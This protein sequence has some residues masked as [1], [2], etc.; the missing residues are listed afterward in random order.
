MIKTRTGRHPRMFMMAFPSN[1][2]DS[3]RAST[4]AEEQQ[5]KTTH[6]ERSTKSIGDLTCIAFDAEWLL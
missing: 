1:Q 2:Q 6:K 5:K 3:Q 4:I